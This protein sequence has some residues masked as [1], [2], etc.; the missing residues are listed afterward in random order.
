MGSLLYCEIYKGLLKL[1]CMKYIVT[2]KKDVDFIEVDN[3]R[4]L[5]I[6]L[7]TFSAAIYRIV[8]KGREMVLT[9]KDEEVFYTAGKYYGKIV[10]RIAGR[11]PYG[12]ITIDGKTYQLDQN[13][14]TNCL[15]GG[16][17]SMS[18]MNHR[19][20]IKEDDNTLTVKF[21]LDTKDM[22]E[23]YPGDTHYE[24][25][26]VFYKDSDSFAIYYNASCSADTYF[27]LTNHVYFNLGE[28]TI[29]DHKITM[30]VKE[31]SFF[32]PENFCIKEFK[33]V[34]DYPIF[35]F[36]KGTVLKDIMED[37]ILHNIKW[38]N[39]LDHRFIFDNSKVV[40]LESK[41]AKMSIHTDLPAV[42]IYSN[43]FFGDDVYIDGSKDEYCKGIAMEFS[44]AYPKFVKKNEPYKC[45]VRYE[46]E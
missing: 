28:R 11:V 46:F 9:P 1:L 5:Q 40:T 14:G 33:D 39:G 42:H 12:K 10:G 25:N 16:K 41:Y 44:Y 34:K 24:S 18:H 26:Y 8:F 17:F 45:M 32:Y 15:H 37:P 4:N 43:G 13:E 31:I 23:G 35:D 36:T 30:P 7:S 22:E 19:Y 2:S 29:L 38:L 20:E 6:T 21:I 3:E 27:N